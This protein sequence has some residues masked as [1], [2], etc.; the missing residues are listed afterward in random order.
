MKNI[1]VWIGL[2]VLIIAT[3]IGE[4]TGIALADWIELAGWSIGMALCVLGIVSKAEKK[5][6]KLYVSIVGIIAGVFLL[7][8]AGISKDTITTVITAVFGLVVLIISILPAL[9]P[10]KASAGK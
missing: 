7:A 9:L 1:L 4:F 8:L 3:T 5:D 6:W 2:V 10:K